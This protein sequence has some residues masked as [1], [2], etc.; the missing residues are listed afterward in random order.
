MKSYLNRISEITKNPPNNFDNTVEKHKKFYRDYLLKY[1]NQ[2]LNIINE[3][4]QLISDYQSLRINNSSILDNSFSSAEIKAKT[5]LFKYWDNSLLSIFNKE[6]PIVKGKFQH[7]EDQGFWKDFFTGLLSTFEEERLK[8]KAKIDYKLNFL[9]FMRECLECQGLHKYIN[10][11]DHRIYKRY[12]LIITFKDGRTESV[13]SRILLSHTDLETEYLVPFFKKKELIINGIIIKY[14]TIK[15]ARITTTLLLDDEIELLGY[16]KGFAWNKDKKDYNSF[17]N[18]CLDETNTFLKNPN[19]EKIKEFFKNN[20]LIYISQSRIDEIACIK[21][22]KWDT[23]K[24]ISLCKELNISSSN[25]LV[26]AVAA[27]Q[28][29][30][31]NHIPPIFGFENFGQ[32]VANYKTGKSIKKSFER[33]NSSMKDISDNHLHSHISKVDSPPNMMQ[34]DFSNDLDVLLAEVCKLLKNK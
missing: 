7:I 14:S 24:L 27:I 2:R 34:V 8:K 33:L 23:T 16:I 21:N 22:K 4:F 9:D 32:V 30:I 28:R 12:N 3:L 31:I 6:I 13:T 26:I 1:K 29:S 5:F 25:N 11:R 18:K 15:K 10:Y 17:S 19:P 20:S